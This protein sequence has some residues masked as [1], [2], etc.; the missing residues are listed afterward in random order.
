MQASIPAGYNGVMPYLLLRDAAGFSQFTQTVLDATEV[1]RSL[2]DDGVIAHGEVSINGCSI[3][4]AEATNDFPPQTAGLFVYVDDADARY[5]KA[6]AAG[7]R[8]VMPPADMPYG[9]SCG[10][11]DPQ[12]NTWWITQAPNA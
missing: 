8:S 11:T 3:M 12:G 5:Q 7:A 9:R 2:R 4:F 10:V 1:R 6:L